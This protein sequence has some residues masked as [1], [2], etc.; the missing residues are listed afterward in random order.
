M[1][2][3]RPWLERGFDSETPVSMLPDLLERLRGTPARLWDRTRDVPVDV[4]TRRVGDT[5]S[6]QEIVGHLQQTEELWAGRL[7]DFEA[8]AAALRPARFESGR[9][10]AERFN[11]RPLSE[12]LD[13]FRNKRLGLVA[14]LEAWADEVIAREAWHPR[15]QRPMGVVGLV[16][17]IA[18]H[19]DHHL[20]RMTEILTGRA[21]AAD[22][23]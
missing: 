13:D 18:E 19:D 5:W 22:K 17:F 14:R 21:N 20:A 7:D 4:L 11:E 23:R 9:V 16:V 8:G 3:K 6:I 12:I 10:E 1:I 2:T 15:L